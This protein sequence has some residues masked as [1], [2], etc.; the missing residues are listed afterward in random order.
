MSETTI[1]CIYCNADVTERPIPAIDDEQAWAALRSEHRDGCE[2][3]ETRAHRWRVG[4]SELISE[5]GIDPGPTVGDVDA[6]RSEAKALLLDD[7]DAT[8][9]ML[10]E[11]WAQAA[12]DYADESAGA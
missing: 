5:S 11:R 8:G 1:E 3:V 10:R 2:W 12:A 4:V 6:I 7:R 9:A